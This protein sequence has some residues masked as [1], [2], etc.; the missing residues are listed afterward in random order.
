[1]TT[2]VLYLLSLSLLLLL[3]YTQD[4]HFRMSKFRLVA[5]EFVFMR[6]VEASAQF[7]SANHYS[8]FDLVKILWKLYW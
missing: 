1:M 8:R 3:S 6:D 4:C 7:D 2:C 5:Q